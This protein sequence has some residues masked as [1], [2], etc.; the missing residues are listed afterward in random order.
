MGLL[1]QKNCSKSAIKIQ[2][3]SKT[4]NFLCTGRGEEVESDQ[5]SEISD[6]TSQKSGRTGRPKAPAKGGRAKATK[7]VK[8][9]P[10]IAKDEGNTLKSKYLI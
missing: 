10:T 9:K 1:L 2:I 4:Y 6:V 5:E 8:P 3:I 7:A